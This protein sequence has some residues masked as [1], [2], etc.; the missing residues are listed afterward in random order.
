[1]EEV[2]A[3]GTDTT[4]THGTSEGWNYYDL[5]N[6]EHVNSSPN[7]TWTVGYGGQ[8]Q[9]STYDMMGNVFEWVENTNGVFRGGS[10]D[11]DWGNYLVSTMRGSNLPAKEYD[12]LGVRVVAV[13][14][15]A[16]TLLLIPGVGALIAARRRMIPGRRVKDANLESVTAEDSSERPRSDGFLNFLE[17]LSRVAVPAHG[18]NPAG[19]GISDALVQHLDK[20]DRGF[21][22][23][24]TRHVDHGYRR[25][26]ARQADKFWDTLLRLD[27]RIR[28]Y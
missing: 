16:T 15:P 19:S 24:A 20:A 3:N 5:D 27:E 2:S 9:N 23:F 25:F 10:Y 11:Y 17:R 22:R 12:H 1:M 18:R 4:P 6:E 26:A 7:Y 14:E 28:K 8:E 21:R 13:P